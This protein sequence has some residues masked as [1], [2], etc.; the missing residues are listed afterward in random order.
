MLIISSI[1]FLVGGVFIGFY[2]Y[3]KALGSAGFL[4]KLAAK[5]A[6]NKLK[7]ALDL[8]ENKP[9]PIERDRQKA[10][11]ERDRHEQGD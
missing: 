10:R 3:H 9:E 7:D 8:P 2:I 4:G 11:R 6:E 5:K 1:C